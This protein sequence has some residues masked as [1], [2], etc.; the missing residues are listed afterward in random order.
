M[1]RKLLLIC[2]LLAALIYVGSDIVAAMRYEGYS[3]ISQSISELRALGSPTR[4]FLIPIL[5]V[6]SALGLVF[7]VGVWS[8][9]GQKRILRVTG[10]LLIALGVVDLFIA[11]FFPMHE[12]GEVA[13]LT[14]TMHIV[15]TA[16]TVL[17]LFL[18]VGTGAFADGKWFRVYSFATLV[19]ILGFGILAGMD[20]ARVAANQPTP[21]LGITERIN[22]Y[23]YMLWL[24]VFSIL[25]L[26][27]VGAEAQDK[28]G[29]KPPQ[30]HLP[31]Q[32]Q[33][34]AHL[35]PSG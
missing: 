20:G 22:V 35:R 3:Y 30:T 5:T 32:G 10:G 17:L 19:T 4:A 12:R 9:A 14:D 13:T 7:G 34:G 27:G 2:G 11:P 18:I 31:H 25:L 23:G 28:L 29:G 24:L 15:V 8:I 33:G 1:I 6:Y 26:R 16:V 21:W